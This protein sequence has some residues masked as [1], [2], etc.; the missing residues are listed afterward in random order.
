M[1][2]YI[3]IS[4]LLLPIVANAEQYICSYPNYTNGEPVILKIKINGSIATVGNKYPVEY[5][6]LENNNL[7]VVLVYSFSAKGTESPK[8]HDIGLFG[9]AID[10]TKMKMI[11]GNITHGDKN[12]SLRTGTCTK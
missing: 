11:R 5:K 6:V 3:L 10:K 9:L 8:Q 1:M 2:K 12:N 4:A 7:G